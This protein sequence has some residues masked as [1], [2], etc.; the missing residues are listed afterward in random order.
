[1]TGSFVISLD[2]ELLWGVRDHSDRQSYGSN[3]LGA[4]DA[5]P[6][7]LDLFTR[8]GIRAT[9]A[10]VGFLFFE[11]KDELISSLPKER[12]VYANP[13]L[14]NYTYLDEV[15]KDESSDPYYLAGSL[16]DK[17][18][19]A[20]GQEI[21]THTMSHF[22]CLED[23][24]TLSAF[25][26]DLAAAVRVARN[27]GIELKSIVFPRNQFT[28]AHLAICARHGIT[29]FR[30]N[31]KSWAYRAAKGAEQTPAR[32]ALRL[33]DAYSG[34]LGPHTFAPARDLPI[35]V[36]ASRFLRPYAGRL[37][38]FHPVHLSTIKRGMSSAAKDHRGYHLW[39][40]PHNFGH[41]LSNNIAGLKEIV[42]HFMHLRDSL[43]MQSLAMGDL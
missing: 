24:Q 21:G 26:A 25:D 17:V 11:S 12:P 30:G 36:P 7:I 39:W 6:Q 4:R 13:R 34:L 37:A 35:D 28:D 14:S 41:N 23:G 16:I 33:L 32:R 29:H 5:V 27:R 40:H 43:G 22:Y 19:Q 2:F 31:P 20:P 8:H 38:V 1:M 18:R 42:A 3:V 10:T 15:G 9:W